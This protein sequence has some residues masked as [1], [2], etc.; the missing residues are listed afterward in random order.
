MFMCAVGVL[1][2]VPLPVDHVLL[3]EC[4]RCQPVEETPPHGCRQPVRRNFGVT[5]RHVVEGFHK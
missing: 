1:S 3:L 5:G 2:A 4:L